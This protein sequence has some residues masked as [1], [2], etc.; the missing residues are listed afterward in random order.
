MAIA[1]VRS[2][3]AQVSAGGSITAVL[4]GVAAG[5]KLVLMSASWQ[6]DSAQPSV[7]TV[8]STPAGIDCGTDCTESYLR[9]AAVTL[10]AVAGSNDLF[11]GWSGGGCSGTGTCTP[12][13]N[14]DASVSVTAASP[15]EKAE[16]GASMMRM[17]AASA[18]ARS[19]AVSASPV[20]DSSVI[21]GL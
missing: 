4:A 20:S 6:G 21:C 18:C 12:A 10:T 3:N 14:G 9:G 2:V 17:P 7:G 13:L 5:N 19:S 15:K 16:T 1:F 11:Q 8:T